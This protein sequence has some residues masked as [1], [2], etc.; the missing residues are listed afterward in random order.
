MITASAAIFNNTSTLSTRLPGVTP[1]WFTS[2]STTIAAMATTVTS[3][4]G[5]PASLSAYC[6]KAI[7]T[8]AMAPVSIMK[9]SAQP[10]RKPTSGC[11]AR[12]RY[13]Y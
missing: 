6:A 10:Y 1:K 4:S 13:T 3:V 8:A 9:I 7:A 2:D 5:C 11:Q 12:E